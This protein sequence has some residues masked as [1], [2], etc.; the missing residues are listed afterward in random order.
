MQDLQT[1]EDQIVR[2]T[3]ELLVDPD[4]SEN[5]NLCDL[6]NRIP[7]LGDEVSKR[8]LKRLTNKKTKVCLLS[9]TLLETLVKNC[10]TI[11]KY[12]GTREYMTALIKSLPKKIRD[13]QKKGVFSGGAIND[14]SEL[15]R[16]DRT[17]LLIQSWAKAFSKS[18]SYPIFREVYEELL[19]KGIRF[20][21]PEKDELA[22]VFTPAAKA[23]TPKESVKKV[24][25][26][27][28]VKERAAEAFRDADC[29]AAAESAKVLE[30][31]VT[32]SEAGTDLVRSDLVQTLV[33]NA[34]ALQARIMTRLNG[35]VSETVLA[36]ILAANDVVNGALNYFQGVATGTMSRKKPEA[37]K[38]DKSEEKKKHKHKEKPQT[39]SGPP[40]ANVLDFD[41]SG[42]TTEAD[43]PK[44]KDSDERPRRE[45]SEHKDRSHKNKDKNTVP[46]LSPPD[47]PF[48]LAP[49]SEGQHGHRVKSPE[50]NRPSSPPSS[51]PANS[52]GM[53]LFDF[54]PLSIPSPSPV[55]AKPTP[56]A[57]PAGDVDEFMMLALRGKDETPK[58]KPVDDLDDFAKLAFR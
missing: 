33:A 4:W 41:F 53:N 27:E 36:E 58:K 23:P 40:T 49:P 29:R 24:V 52:G 38:S 12:V 3:H 11:H 5:L 16:I 13:P 48:A 54:D 19:D 21:E 31:M 32:A 6:V 56:T 22:P 39:I 42:K 55:A 25:P 46:K 2:A 15:E 43:T 28:A 26:S 9:L 10:P 20:P 18:Q 37:P 47:S 51:R 44:K 17:L 34:R 45:H 30:E 1:L 50:K 14:V 7:D 8:V 57:A 35:P